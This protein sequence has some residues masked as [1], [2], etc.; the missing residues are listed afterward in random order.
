MSKKKNKR[1]YVKPRLQSSKNS[2]KDQL[3]KEIDLM[4]RKTVNNLILPLESR[5]D[6]LYSAL[7]NVK[8]N[9]VVS[10]TLLENKG[11]F[12]REEFFEEF[13]KYEKQ[14]VGIVDGAGM[15]PGFPIFSLFN[16]ED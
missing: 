15:M 14:E 1:G 12:D 2:K 9:V 3:L 10:N 7:Q 5:I 13:S 6:A 4:I 8:S 11:V 16:V